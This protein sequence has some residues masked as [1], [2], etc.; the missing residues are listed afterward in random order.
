M[1]KEKQDMVNWKDKI[2]EKIFAE[3]GISDIAHLPDMDK[4]SNIEI[5]SMRKH[6]NKETG[7]V[8]RQM[9]KIT[10]GNNVYFLKQACRQSF[11]NIVNE[12]AAINVLQDFDLIPPEV[13]AYSL[14]NEQQ[15]G[16]I[17]LKDLTDFYS[18]KDL[19]TDIAP[20]DEIDDFLSRKEDVLKAVA[21]RIR[22]V[23]RK[24]YSYPDWFA[25]HLY[26]KK[27]SDEIVLIDLER[28]R[29]LDKCPWY[30]GF[31]VTSLFVKRKAWRK[32]R[33]SL[34]S[35]ALPDR[36]LRKILHE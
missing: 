33:K 16:F 6:L 3:A 11:I 12:F 18:I 24:G 31:P 25:K 19:I 1:N 4:N 2:A 5:H 28:F 21:E 15:K 26:I 20:H 27:G 13:A 32:L 23:H 35:H 30:F 10:I 34:K 14:D 29:P 36:L 7:E 22:K 9:T 8:D 17:L